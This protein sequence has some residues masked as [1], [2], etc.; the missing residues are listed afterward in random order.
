MAK[1]YSDVTAI[2]K[3]PMAIKECC[4]V[5]VALCF[6]VDRPGGGKLRKILVECGDAVFNGR[7]WWWFFLG[8]FPSGG[9]AWP[10]PKFAGAGVSS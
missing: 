7:C 1:K 8:L 3:S 4:V 10:P 9:A 2:R 5:Q 6:F